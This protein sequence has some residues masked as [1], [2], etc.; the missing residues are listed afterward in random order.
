MIITANGLTTE[1]RKLWPHMEDVWPMDK[2]FWSPTYQEVKESLE[3]VKWYRGVIKEALAE[4]D[5][6]IC[7]GFKDGV[8][9]CDN[10]ALELQADISR[11]RVAIKT[12]EELKADLKPWAFGTALCMRVNGRDVNHTINICR[13]SDKGFVFVEPQDSTTWLADKKNDTP[14]F[15]EMR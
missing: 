12:D 2:E 9:D 14:Y 11:Y 3:W 13:T 7:N 5:T 6:V 1:L 10:F 4:K 8:H 15:V